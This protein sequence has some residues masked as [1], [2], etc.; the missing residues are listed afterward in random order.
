MRLSEVS[1]RLF[2]LNCVHS[3]MCRR[4]PSFLCNF[5]RLL[6]LF[7]FPFFEFQVASQSHKRLRRFSEGDVRTTDTWTPCMA[8][9]SCTCHE[10]TQ[11]N[12]RWRLKAT[13]DT[14]ATFISLFYVRDFLNK[15]ASQSVYEISLTLHSFTLYTEKGV[16][17]QLHMYYVHKLYM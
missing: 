10:T 9:P 16:A 6:P 11:Q 17:L 8:V 12:L 15:Q 1:K 5:L 7:F 3:F 13:W 14:V 2:P 4:S